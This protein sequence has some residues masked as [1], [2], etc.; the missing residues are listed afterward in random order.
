MVAIG[1][2]FGEL[3]AH[4]Y[5]DA[6][7]ADPRIDALRGKMEVKENTTF[8]DEYYDLEKRAIG[9][10]I[11][12][13]FKDG[14]STDRVEVSYPIGH[15]V[16]REEGIPVLKQKF[17]NSMAGVFDKDQMTAILDA[18][19][20]KLDSTSVSDFMALFVVSEKGMQIA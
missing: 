11:Q 7:A 6:T 14:A 3:T 8:T 18:F 19:G 5:T 13:H 1:L 17:N 2:I 9:N 16:R 12:V 15:R 20:D 10:S 4:H